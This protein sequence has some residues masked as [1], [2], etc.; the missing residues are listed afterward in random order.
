M[1]I[2][3]SA[4]VGVNVDTRPQQHNHYTRNTCV[5]VCTGV[6]MYLLLKRATNVHRKLYICIYIC[7]TRRVVILLQKANV[8]CC[9][10]HESIPPKNPALHPPS[11]LIS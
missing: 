3:T 1:K 6:C 8:T 7:C 9:Q 11:E 10:H 4:L 2:N 5:Y